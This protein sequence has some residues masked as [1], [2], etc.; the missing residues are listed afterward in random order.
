[1]EVYGKPEAIRLD[2][3]PEMPSHTFVDWAQDQGIRRLYF[4]VV[5]LTGVST[6]QLLNGRPSQTL[7][8]KTPE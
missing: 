1:M 8:W 4:W 6:T 2:N 5:L 7:G 3:A